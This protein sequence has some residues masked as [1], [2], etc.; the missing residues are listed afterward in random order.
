MILNFLFFP[1]IPNKEGKLCSYVLGGYVWERKV[2][3]NLILE[4]HS[5][6]ATHQLQAPQAGAGERI[7]T[8]PTG[9]AH[10]DRG[11]LEGK[12]PG[13]YVK[14]RVGT[15]PVPRQLFAAVTLPLFPALLSLPK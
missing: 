14:P 9:L 15:F 7:L 10:L 11:A 4:S 8:G 6:P 12:I 3:H 5:S 2:F 1:N 13:G